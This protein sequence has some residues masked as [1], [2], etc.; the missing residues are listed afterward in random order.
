MF[1]IGYK[2]NS[3][4]IARAFILRLHHSEYTSDRSA[5]LPGFS[6]VRCVIARR[7]AMATLCP[8]AS[9]SRGSLERLDQRFRGKWLCEIGEAPGLKRSLANS[10]VS[11]P[12]M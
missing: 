7:L 3:C 11:F 2:V 4:A 10:R 6:R 8:S 12:V 9:S 5:R 1:R